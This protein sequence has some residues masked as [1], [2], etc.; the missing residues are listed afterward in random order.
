MTATLAPIA[1]TTFIPTLMPPTD[2]PAIPDSIRA[3]VAAGATLLDAERPGWAGR[4]DVDQLQMGSCV[5]CVLG[6]LYGEYSDGC[7]ALGFPRS[8]DPQWREAVRYGFASLDCNG[9]TEAWKAEYTALRTA[10]VA[11]IRT[12]LES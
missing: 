2:P 10:W 1:P 12:R 5:R 7:E 6:Q 3:R 11:E 4:I 8:I 9:L